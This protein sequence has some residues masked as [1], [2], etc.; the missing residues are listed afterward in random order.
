[1]DDNDV[2]VVVVDDLVDAANALAMTLELNG[3]KVRT[4]HDGREALTVIH[5]HQPHCV[6]LDVD[7][8]GID[9]CELSRRLREQYGRDVVLIAMSAH[10]EAN[11][12][13]AETFDRVDHYLRKPFDLALLQ[14]VLPRLHD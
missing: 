1:M 6:M 14:K 12:R 4:A 5:E 9:G 3:Y 11:H 8:P 7:M 13:V 10:D 2:R